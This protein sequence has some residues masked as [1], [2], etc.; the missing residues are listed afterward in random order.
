MTDYFVGTKA[1]TCHSNQG[2][3]TKFLFEGPQGSPRTK[4]GVSCRSLFCS[5]SVLLASLPSRFVLKNPGPH[6]IQHLICHLPVT[7][8]VSLLQS[9]VPSIGFASKPPT[10]HFPNLP[11]DPANRTIPH[12]EETMV[13]ALN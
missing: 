12:G 13:D 8:A 4:L 2:K 10:V 3:P 1:Q 9:T 5:F 7:L 6:V 11:H